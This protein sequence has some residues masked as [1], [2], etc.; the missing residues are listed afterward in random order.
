MTRNREFI[1]E[2][3]RF[4]KSKPVLISLLF[5]SIFVVILTLIYTFVLQKWVFFLTIQNYIIQE[6]SQTTPAGL[7][8]LGFFGSLFFIPVPIDGI[9]YYA[10]IR[11]ANIVLAVLLVII[12]NT[13]GNL[14]SYWIGFKL[15]K[16]TIQ[17][18]SLKKMYAAKRWVNRFGPWAIL[19]FN[20][21]PLPGS[22]LTFALGIAKYNVY[23]MVTFFT[24]GITIKFIVIA[25]FASFWV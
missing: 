7:F 17:F 10:I 2:I 9:F 11:G 13:I 19:F 15:S 14:I 8:F 4:E 22:V 20:L 12:G 5:T 6:I 1:Y 21:T 24:I 18:V 3:S 23:R 25:L 16:F